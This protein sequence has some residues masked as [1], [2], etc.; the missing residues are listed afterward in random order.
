ME[1]PIFD[2]DDLR[3]EDGY[4]CNIQNR[5]TSRQKNVAIEETVEKGVFPVRLGKFRRLN[6]D[7]GEVA[8]GETS[9]S[10]LDAR[11]CYSMGSY[12]YVLGNSDLRISLNH[13]AK[14]SIEGDEE[15]KKISSVSKGESYSVSKIWLWSKK[16]KFSSSSD[17]Q[18]GL[19]MPY[20]LNTDLPW[21]EKKEGTL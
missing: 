5:F 16:G 4:P 10:N 11:R 3:E 7:A 18:M 13:D 9:S 14:L 19:P 20:S 1:N 12:Q 17:T 15:A 21:M 6:L 2:F 8:G